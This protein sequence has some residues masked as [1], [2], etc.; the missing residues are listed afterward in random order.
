LN[1]RL[2]GNDFN[3]DVERVMEYRNFCNTIF[4]TTKF[5]ILQLGVG[6]IPE[7]CAKVSENVLVELSTY[8]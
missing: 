4:D 3:M 2:I 1:S 7:P 8:R 5:A 6:F